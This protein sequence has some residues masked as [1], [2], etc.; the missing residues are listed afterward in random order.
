MSRLDI[1][2]IGSGDAVLAMNA[3]E[4]F[5]PTFVDGEHIALHSFTLPIQ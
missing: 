4:T 1:G 5:D 2:G 3:F